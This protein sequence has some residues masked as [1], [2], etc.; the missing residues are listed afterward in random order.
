MFAVAAV[1]PILGFGRL[2]WRAQKT[3]SEA[4]A[5][6]QERGHA[7]ITYDDFNRDN[8]ELTTRPVEARNEVIWDICL[9]GTGLVVGA[10]AS[11][12]AL[13]IPAI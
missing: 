8:A 7:K 12:W 11:I 9:V 4:R 6:I 3:L 10:A 2:F 5:T 13:Y 1:L